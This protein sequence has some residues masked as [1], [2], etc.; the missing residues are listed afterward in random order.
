M[1]TNIVSV[2]HARSKSWQGMCRRI[3]CFYFMVTI[4][5][6]VSHDANE[7]IVTVPRYWTERNRTELN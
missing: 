3:F 6:Q 5:M 7:L 1:V 2:P 4:K